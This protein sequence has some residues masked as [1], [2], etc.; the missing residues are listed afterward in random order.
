MSAFAIKLDLDARLI[1]H[2]T[3]LSDS[4][5]RCDVLHPLEP[6]TV[7]SIDTPLAIRYR[8]SVHSPTWPIAILYLVRTL[9]RDRI[10]GSFVITEVKWSNDIGVSSFEPAKLHG[11][12]PVLGMPL[13]RLPQCLN[14]R[15]VIS[16]SGR[17]PRDDQHLPTSCIYPVS[18]K[19]CPKLQ[20]KASTQSKEMCLL[21][22]IAAVV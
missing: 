17:W 16:T 19:L 4:E 15:T 10:Y 12:T 7:S 11:V 18:I 3:R 13:E 14:I 6:A 22:H 8:N 5:R 9:P 21:Y 1:G 20:S 2:L